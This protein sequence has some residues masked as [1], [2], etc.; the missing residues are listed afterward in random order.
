L[1]EGTKMAKK[2]RM[3][4]QDRDDKFTM[5]AI[6]T[7]DA[8][9]RAALAAG[10]TVEA[11]NLKYNRD[12][13]LIDKRAGIASDAADALVTSKSDAAEKLAAANLA[14]QTF[15]KT[16]QGEIAASLYKT[17]MVDDNINPE[18]RVATFLQ[19]A[20]AGGPKFLREMGIPTT[21]SVGKGVTGDGAEEITLN[22]F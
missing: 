1:L 10:A 15:L 17:I 20:G 6:Q 14:K 8:D 19:R 18:D 12:V 3:R 13:E 22:S 16:K 5:M 2:D 7:A 21:A 4:K 11:A 9:R